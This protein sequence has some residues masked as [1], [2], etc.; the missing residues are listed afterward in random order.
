MNQ[1][2]AEST[3][4]D[5]NQLPPARRRRAR[6]LLAPL[7][8]DE[9]A[10]LLD[11]MAHRTSP[12]FD[13][14]LFSFL[15]GIV[16]SLGLLLN[17]PSMLMLGVLVAPV[18]A[19]VIG[20]AFGTVVGSTRFFFRSFIG[21]LI[22][23]AM[24]ILAGAL[25][26]LMTRVWTPRILLFGSYFGQL[27]WDNFIVLIAGMVITA[28]AMVQSDRKPLLPSIALVYELYIPLSLAGMGITSGIPDLW[29]DGAVVFAV[30]LSWAVLLGAFTLALL[31]FRPLSLFGY[32]LS[33][34]MVLVGVILLIGI[35]GAGAAIGGQMGM[36]T[37]VPT[38]TYTPTPVPP[39]ETHTPTPVPPTPTLTSTITP[40]LTQTPTATPSPT[41]TPVYAL[42][43]AGSGDPPG[44]R[45]RSEPGGTVIRSYLN[46]TLVQ[47]LPDPVEIDG[48]VWVQIIVIED[49]TQGW[50][51]QSLLLAATPAPDF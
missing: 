43:N 21:L 6:R 36:P 15:A 31:G 40:T 1:L 37:P 4:D 39:T 10:V 14:Y 27:S 46:N 49:G 19:P 33:G 47:I 25:V 11:E 5:P 34:A 12:S 8:A 23:G 20:L 18:M 13:F 17:S 44:A 45:I 28:A 42:I 3:P 2:N 7:G 22:G 41:P 32:T 16:L 26:G 30:Y 24:V 38:L 48:L 51:L 50:I 35:S 29:P 9:R